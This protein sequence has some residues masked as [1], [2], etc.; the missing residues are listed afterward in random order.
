MHNTLDIRRLAKGNR[1]MDG[2]GTFVAY[3]QSNGGST[4]K[5]F[6]IC[7]LILLLVF[8]ILY[9]K[10]SFSSFKAIL[11]LYI[12]YLFDSHLVVLASFSKS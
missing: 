2:H 11:Y 9:A 6:R 1:M 4:G 3:S 5:L 8:F 12:V 7:H 10:E